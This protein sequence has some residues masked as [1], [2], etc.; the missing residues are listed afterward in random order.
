MNWKR[1]KKSTFLQSASGEWLELRRSLLTASN[2]GKIIKR[3]NDTSCANI[4]KELLYKGSLNHVASMKHGR[5]NESKALVKL[6]EQTNKNIDKCGLF[7][8]KVLPFLGATPDGLSGEDEV[9]EVK[10]PL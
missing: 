2:F 6:M 8:D 4:V 10:C 3:R 9:I 1:L 7:I 5:E